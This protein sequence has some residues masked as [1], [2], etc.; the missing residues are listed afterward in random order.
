V[1]NEL[2]ELQRAV[3]IH[4]RKVE[5]ANATL[6]AAIMCAY[7]AKSGDHPAFTLSE[8][9]QALGVSRQRAHQL[10]RELAMRAS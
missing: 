2:T 1:T 8:I 10:V 6:D 7:R 4:R 9:G 5:Q 3:E